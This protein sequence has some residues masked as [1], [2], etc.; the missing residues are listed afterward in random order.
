MI[1]FIAKKVRERKGFD[2]LEDV[3]INNLIQDAAKRYNKEASATLC[4]QHPDIDSIVE[5]S[6]NPINMKF[7]SVCCESFRNSV[8][9]KV[10]R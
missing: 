10:K 2:G 1:K 8:S 6:G 7:T 9:L 5:I 3:I 4:K